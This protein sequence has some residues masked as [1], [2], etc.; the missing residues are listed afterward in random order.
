MVTLVKM[1]PRLKISSY[2][3]ERLSKIDTNVSTG[4]LYGLMYDGTLLVVGLSIELFENEKNTYSQLLL[5]LPAEIELCGVVKFSD[6]LTMG[7]SVKEILQDVDITDN[8]LVMIVNEKKD[9]KT[10]FLVHDKFEETKYE[11]LSSDEL[12][13]QFLHVRLDTVLPLSCEATI[14]GVKNI[15]QNKRKKV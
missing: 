1:S 3:I 10:H 2:V 5:N 12:W 14:S 9:M 15:M 11:V 13:T 8:P 6:S 7:T 4:C